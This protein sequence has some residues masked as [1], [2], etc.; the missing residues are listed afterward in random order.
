MCSALMS[1]I[2]I[3]VQPNRADKEAFATKQVAQQYLFLSYLNVKK[4]PEVICCEPSVVLATVI[5]AKITHV[6]NSEH[7]H[8]LLAHDDDA[9]ACN[10]IYDNSN[11][12]RVPQK[13]Q[14]I[15]KLN[16]KSR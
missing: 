8:S 11:V 5:R 9:A 15:Q 6:I 12:D 16:L 7:W 2:Y 14:Q 3:Y 10:Q 13:L 4:H 1:L